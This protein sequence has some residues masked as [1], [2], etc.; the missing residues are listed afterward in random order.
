MFRAGLSH[1]FKGI[2]AEKV[3]CGFHFFVKT[4]CRSREIRVVFG[5]FLYR[6]QISLIR[7]SPRLFFFIF[8][9]FLVK[10]K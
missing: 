4:V 5:L 9:L 2:F 6:L 7:G 8:I 10:T 3:V 1:G